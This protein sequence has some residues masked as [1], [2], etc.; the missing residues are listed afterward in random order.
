V[1]IVGWAMIALVLI[2]VIINYIIVITYTVGVK[3]KKC[4]KRCS[5]KKKPEKQ[6]YVLRTFTTSTSIVRLNS[7]NIIITKPPASAE[8]I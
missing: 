8:P 5:S 6:D 4:M 7:S 2:M 3:I 1:R